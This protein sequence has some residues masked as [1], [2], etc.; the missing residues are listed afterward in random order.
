M[1]KNYGIKFGFVVLIAFSICAQAHADDWTQFRGTGGTSNAA[2]A[3]IPIKIAES[4]NVKWDVELPGKGPSSP[5][6]IGDQVIVTCSFGDKQDRLAVV[7]YNAK[8]GKQ[9]WRQDFWATGRSVCHPLSANAAPTPTSDGK[10]IYA[11]FSSNDLAC[12][13]L[14]GNLKWFRGLAYDYPK[15]AND[16]GM[17][18]SPVVADGVVVVQIENQ[19]DSFAAGID[20]TTGK[21]L[22]RKER[23][24]KACWASP[25][26]IRGNP[27]RP[28]MVVLQSN[29]KTTVHNV[30][31][32][33]KVWE[34][35]GRFSGIPSPVVDGNRLYLPVDGTTAFEIADDGKFTKLWNNPRMAPGTSS[36]I[37]SKKYLFS[38][39]RGGI[40]NC[41]DAKS[42]ERLWQVRMNSGSGFW[43]T[44]LLAGGHL[45][46]FSQG[47]KAQVVEV[48]NSG[49]KIVYEHEYKETFLGSPAVSNNAM[50]M[51][52][53]NRLRKIAG[54]Q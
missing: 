47:G 10:F 25:V 15:A 2:G 51:R 37:V 8:S 52:S 6:V 40:T 28:S 11:F 19:A 21:T 29:S 41:F 38:L 24:P 14:E 23:E 20:T 34:Y 50:F 5:I 18:S 30:K 42:G 48:S 39:N 53:D 35:E 13:D 4:N 44:P 17:S 33:E 12:L 22:W 49:G 54:D 32:G 31:S 36:L 7:S 1:T 9:N 16:T 45:Y 27:N 46:F 43:S 26:I 3:V